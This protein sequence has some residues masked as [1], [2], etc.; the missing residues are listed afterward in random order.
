MN[1][2]K[3]HKSIFLVNFIVIFIILAYTEYFLYVTSDRKYPLFFIANDINH[4]SMSEKYEDVDSAPY[5]S[6]LNILQDNVFKRPV[7]LNYTKTPVI[8]FGGSFAWGAKLQEEQTF[9]FKLS[10]I[11][12]RPIYNRSISG[13]GVQHMLYQLKQDSFYK[14]MPKPDYVIYMY[15]PN[16][17]ARMHKYYFIKIHART[18]C[19][20]Y[21][22]YNEHFGK[23][24]EEK[25]FQYLPYSRIW[26]GLILPFMARM[27]EKN[28]NKSFKLFE[29][30]IL[31]CRREI[32]NHWGKDVKFI[33]FDYE[34]AFND[35]KYDVL[36][37]ENI[38]KLKQNRID[39]IKTSDIS[40]INPDAPQYTVD[41]LSH[42]NEDA[43]N[44]FT[45]LFT[46]KVRKTYPDF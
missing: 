24:Y 23:F 35:V 19:Y 9:H 6:L 7:G 34:A 12:K 10:D 46:E 30:H 32:D 42:P 38:E 41:F 31:E 22:K 39:V 13:W 14:K 44:V 8:L 5:D 16:H 25:R 18:Y 15:I 45:P 1:W 2:F 20:N 29:K 11:I 33:I 27:N 43:W 4:P 21:L 40:D 17:I 3:K 26:N 37:K 28:I 36:T